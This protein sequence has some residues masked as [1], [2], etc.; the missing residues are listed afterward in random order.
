M[1]VPVTLESFVWTSID[2]YQCF[3]FFKLIIFIV[4]FS[5]KVTCAFLVYKNQ[6]RKSDTK[7]LFDSGN[8]DIFHIFIRQRFKGY[9]CISG[10]FTR[11]SLETNS[12]NLYLTLKNNS[13]IPKN[14]FKKLNINWMIWRMKNRFNDFFRFCFCFWFWFWFWTIMRYTPH[15]QLVIIK[16]IIY[17]FIY[18]FIFLFIYLIL[19][20]KF[21]K[22]QDWNRF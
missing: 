13:A 6:W 16:N 19:K 21:C 2:S 12:F 7:K 4:G 22:W 18:L 11:G 15:H 10:I 5:A 14:C 20:K 1:A 3:C 8:Y 17:L 9:R